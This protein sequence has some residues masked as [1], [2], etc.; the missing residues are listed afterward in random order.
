MLLYIYM[1]KRWQDSD[2][3]EVV[4][5]CTSVRQVLQKLN[6]KPA[7]G[8]Y[9]TIGM[10]IQRLGLDT[11][12]FTGKGWNVGDKAGLSRRNTISLDEILVENSTYTSSDKLRK[13]LFS[14]GIKARRCEKCLNDSWM[15]EPI[16]LELE[17][18][19]G[20]HSDNRLENLQILCPNCH[21][22]TPTYRG[23]NIG[24]RG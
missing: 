21:A 24:K 4:V 19:N 5:G 3:A 11:S 1:S 17:H 16:P 2:L 10:A 15:G 20:R 22:Q 7:G 13:R 9:K 23:K 18:I 6:L 8:N 12:H 14:E